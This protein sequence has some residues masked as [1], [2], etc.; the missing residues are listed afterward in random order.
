MKKYIKIVLFIL[1]VLWVTTGFLAKIDVIFLADKYR[2]NG[3]DLWVYRN[4]EYQEDPY[5]KYND[6]Y[7]EEG[8]VKNE[9]DT[10]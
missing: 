4:Y 5:R 8:F 9:T 7:E 10:H 3:F 1:L 2:S 6:K